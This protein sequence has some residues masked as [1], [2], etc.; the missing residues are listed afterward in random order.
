MPVVQR[1][2][3][4]GDGRVVDPPQARRLEPLAQAEGV[5]R[6]E[7]LAGLQQAAHD[8]VVPQG[9]RHHQRDAAVRTTSRMRRPSA[10]L[11]AAG[12][13]NSTARRVPPR[14]RRWGC[15]A[16]AAPPPRPRRR[17]IRDQ[18]VVVRVGP[19]VERARLLNGAAAR[20][21]ACQRHQTASGRSRA[22][23]CAYRTPCLP[24]PIRP[25][26]KRVIRMSKEGCVAEPAGVYGTLTAWSGEHGC[27]GRVTVAPARPRFRMST[28][29]QTTDP[30][31]PLLLVP[32]A[33][34]APP[35][36]STR[37]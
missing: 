11:V 25:N 12:F 8:A 29:Q 22:R 23:C 13:S 19:A 9:L 15:V 4:A 1:H 17:R 33:R 7:A 5:D 26:P 21:R 16:S 10:R 32:G 27:G 2:P 37:C 35:S 18:V 34:R 6:A 14:L 24:P 30:P 36:T 3:A 31:W 28:R 20:S